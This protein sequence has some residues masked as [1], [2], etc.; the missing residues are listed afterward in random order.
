[1]IGK[2]PRKDQRDLFR[3]MLEDFIDM[4][5]ELVLLANKIDWSYFEKELGVYYSANGAPSVPIRMMV[6]C[7]LLKH[8]YNLGDE[9]LPEYWVRD[10]Y[11]QYFCGCVFFEHRFPFDPSDFV[12][13]RNRIAEEGMEKIFAYS[14]KIHGKEVEKKS[15][16]V[17]SDTTVQQ[18]NTTFPTDAKL[19]KKV[20]DKCNKIAEKEGIEQRRRYTRESKQ[21]LRDTYNSTHPKR[22]K[23]A[24]K[25]KKR[26]KTIAGGQIRE[27]ERKMDEEQKRRYEKE[28]ELYKRAVNQR[29]EDKD[30]IYS[31]HKP[32]THCISKGKPHRPY[33][34]GNKVGLI[35]TGKKGKKIITAIRAFTGNPFDGH[36]I[37]PLLE[38]MEGNNLKL[39]QELVYDRGGRG[40]KEIRGV[41]IITPGKPK[42]SDTAYQKQRKRRKFRARSGIEPII[43]HLKKDF[44]MEQNYLMGE[45]G[46]QINAFLAAS[47]WNLKKMMEKLKE[48]FFCFIF[49]LLFRQNFYNLAA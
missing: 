14:V 1:M 24:K 11:F 13:F 49:R 36:T 40:K 31:L 3:P 33:E 6:G 43:G 17:L 4:N 38:Q 46:I 29:K 44:R 2:S 22:V 8:L 27:L 45:A 5:H 9:R 30:K 20:I 25:A 12:H 47:A 41:K 16:L 21:L 48:E 42:A 10:V 23:K 35:T 26:L 34:F 18:N 32:F 19:C 7:M 28:L 39:P 37:D 15:K